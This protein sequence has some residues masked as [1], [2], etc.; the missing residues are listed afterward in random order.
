MILNLGPGILAHNPFHDQHFVTLCDRRNIK[1]N[2]IVEAEGARDECKERIDGFERRKLAKLRTDDLAIAEIQPAIDL[3]L[4][5][6]TL[7][8]N[9]AGLLAQIQQLNDVGERK[10]T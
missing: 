7:H 6:L 9:R 8:K 3:L 4:T 10:I 2:I 5:T 1:L